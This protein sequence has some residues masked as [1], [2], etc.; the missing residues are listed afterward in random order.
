MVFNVAASSGGA[1]SV[2]EDF[3]N[4]VRDSK[5]K[6]VKWF[7]VVSTPK[8]QET[9]NI[10]I[11]RFPWI[12]KNWGFRVFFDNI[13]AKR[14]VKK[15]KIN[16]IFSLQNLTVPSVKKTV[17]QVVY[18][19]Q[20]LPFT[21]YKFKF[22]EHK[23]FWIYQNVIGRRIIRSI[24]SAERVIVQTHWIKEAC[25]K[26]ARDD[27]DKYIVIPPA[28][29]VD[30]TRVFKPNIDSSS[31]FFYPANS[32]FY[33]NHRIII[34]ACKELKKE[35]LKNFNIIFTLTGEENEHI[36]QLYKRVKELDLPVKFIGAITRKEVYDF[37]EKSILVFPS[38]IETYGL[39]LLEVKSMGGMILA[40][41]CTFSHEV[42]DGYNNV[43]YFNPFTH[44]ELTKLMINVVNRKIIYRP[45]LNNH[46]KESDYDRDRSIVEVLLDV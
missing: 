26:S 46:K 40:S 9:E 41:D 34:E 22:R 29:S 10:K 11:L 13:I 32:S 5:D 1:L 19:H 38:Y 14:L 3:Y 2:L 28:L 30:E 42:L 21:D 37:Y 39:P 7:F 20:S 8:L 35:G 18:M 31:T 23:L 4:E 12:K 36:R 33:K 17:P 27:R 44:E 24:K 15:Y 6:S 16:K 45:P 43:F 25:I